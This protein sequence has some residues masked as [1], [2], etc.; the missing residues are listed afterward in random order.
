MFLIGCD[1][2]L[3]ERA[4]G[5]AL[6]PQINSGLLLKVFLHQM[7]STTSHPLTKCVVWIFA[8]LHSWKV[9]VQ[10]NSQHFTKDLNFNSN[11]QNPIEKSYCH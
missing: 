6:E 1:E 11:V 2:G 7:G 3:T 9:T 10:Q 5:R 4:P 8:K